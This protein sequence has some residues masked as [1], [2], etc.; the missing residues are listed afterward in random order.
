M[1]NKDESVKEKQVDLS[2]QVVMPTH[3]DLLDA[4]KYG[5]TLLRLSPYAVFVKKVSSNQKTRVMNHD[6]IAVNRQVLS[7]FARDFDYE[8]LLDIQ[9]AERTRLTDSD[10]QFIEEIQQTPEL[11]HI[12]MPEKSPEQS[13]DDLEKQIEDWK[14]RNPKKEM[15]VVSEVY[16][17][18]MAKKI[19]VAKRNGIRKY[20]IKFRSFKRYGATFSKF[21]FTLKTA[22]LYSI[23]FGVSPTKW[24]KT[25]AT[26]LLPAIH[27]KANAVARWIAWGGR[28]APLAL[29]CEDWK[30]KEI[31]NASQGQTDYEGRNRIQVV[32]STS[33]QFNTALEK[34]DT[35]NQASL[36]IQRLKP[37]EKTVFERLFQ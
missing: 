30:Y 33:T 37:L 25:K 24:K 18:E 36:M 3:K 19:A 21:L 32:S 34:I 15:I 12:C 26:M 2:K 5:L 10:M 17:E 1:A 16:T 22:G 6:Q 11:R 28:K 8:F 31:K 29:L 7:D 27:F 9:L 4:R 23:V 14:E 35:T 20:A 13:A